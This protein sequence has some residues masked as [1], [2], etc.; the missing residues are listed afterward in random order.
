M[1]QPGKSWVTAMRNNPRAGFVQLSEIIEFSKR[2][3][4]H[5]ELTIVLI[6]L[7]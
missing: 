3:G 4:K 6:K 1:N 5:F 2:D 7:L